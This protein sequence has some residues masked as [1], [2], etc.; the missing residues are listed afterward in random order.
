MMKLAM[1]L[2]SPYLHLYMNSLII[3]LGHVAKPMVTLN[4]FYKVVKLGHVVKPSFIT[5]N[6]QTTTTSYLDLVIV[7]IDN[8]IT[9]ICRTFHSIG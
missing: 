6:L 7:Y 5:L 3:K 4:H 9:H 8:I 1:V 2:Y